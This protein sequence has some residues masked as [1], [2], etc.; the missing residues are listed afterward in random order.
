[1]SSAP[2]SSPS[3]PA[4]AETLRLALLLAREEAL[5]LEV[6]RLAWSGD[7]SLSLRAGDA[8]VPVRFSFLFRGL[9]FSV[10]IF[11]GA[12]PRVALSGEL[13]KLPFTAE[14]PH[15]RRLL[16]R[17][18]AATERLPRGALRI[19]AQQD[20]QLQAEAP[21]PERPTPA[22]VIAT[23]TALLLDLLPFL[24]L[25]EE[26]LARRSRSPVR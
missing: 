10:E 6:G 26:A 5:P 23:V 7:G 12:V 3:Q 14:D 1:M 18:A 9:P 15:D 24:D 25:A 13:G 2:A 4:G 22:R 8:S 21:V 17:I 20:L 19:S 16:K 11:G